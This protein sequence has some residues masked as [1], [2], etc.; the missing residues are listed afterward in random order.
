MLYRKEVTEA[1]KNYWSGKAVLISGHRGRY[2]IAFTVFFYRIFH[3]HHFMLLHPQN[4]R[5]RRNSLNAPCGDCLFS[6]AGIHYQP[7]GKAGRTCE[8]RTAALPHRREPD[9][10]LGHC[11]PAAS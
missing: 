4:Q 10:H 1:R 2:V 9:H 3:P 5:F 8:E 7:C 6:S 11:Q